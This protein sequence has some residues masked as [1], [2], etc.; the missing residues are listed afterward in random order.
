MVVVRT[1]AMNDGGGG[2]EVGNV[3]R[4]VAMRERE[5]ERERE[6]QWRRMVEFTKLSLI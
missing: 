1:V 3:A 2:G 6:I 5:R 4:T